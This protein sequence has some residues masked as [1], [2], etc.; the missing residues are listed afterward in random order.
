V[1]TQPRLT[2]PA[3][4][5][6]TDDVLS[7]I[8]AMVI[9]GVAGDKQLLPARVVKV[10]LLTALLALGSRHVAKIRRENPTLHSKPVSKQAVGSTQFAGVAT[11]PL[12]VF[13]SLTSQPLKLQWCNTPGVQDTRAE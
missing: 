12:I 7:A 9:G 4:V 13:V 6:P 3:Q 11:T 2:P 10:K 8:A 5:S 1:K